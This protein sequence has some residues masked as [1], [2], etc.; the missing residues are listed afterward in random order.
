MKGAREYAEL[1]EQSQQHDK[2]YLQVESHARGKT[3]KIWVLPTDDLI[4]GSIHNVEDA[5][6]VYGVVSGNPGW[7]ETYGWIHKGKW[8]QDFERLVEERKE[9]LELRRIKEEAKR[10]QAELDKENKLQSLLNSY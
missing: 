6:T 4:E 9:Q 7:T 8:V 2:L 1:F 5:V 3:F 10:K